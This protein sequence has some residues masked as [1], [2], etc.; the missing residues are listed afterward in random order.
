MG[1]IVYKSREFMV[2]GESRKL[3]DQI[4]TT[5]RMQRAQIGG[6]VRLQTLKAHSRVRLPSIRLH[7]LKVTLIGNQAFEN[8][9]YNF[10]LSNILF[11]GKTRLI[12]HRLVFKEK[13]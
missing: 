9:R 13:N 3:R 5:H 10:I 12:S 6:G 7:L 11:K 2:V 1:W 8:T 4:L